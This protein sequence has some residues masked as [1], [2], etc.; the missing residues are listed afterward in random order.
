MLSRSHRLKQA[1]EGS[2]SIA[3]SV[4]FIFNAVFS[5]LWIDRSLG[6][7]TDNTQPTM[8]STSL[9]ATLTRSVKSYSLGCLFFSGVM[10]LLSFF[11]FKF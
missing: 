11:F 4:L 10:H 7:L 1:S 9:T 6:Y 8:L 2:A 3:Q 5:G